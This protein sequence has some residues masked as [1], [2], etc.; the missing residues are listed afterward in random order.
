MTRRAAALLAALI[1]LTG[2]ALG[3]LASATS[4]ADSTSVATSPILDSQRFQ[5]G[6]FRTYVVVQGQDRLRVDVS[7]VVQ[8]TQAGE[9][10]LVVEACTLEPYQPC[11]DVTR[12]QAFSYVAGANRVRWRFTLVTASPTYTLSSSVFDDASEG[13]ASSFTSNQ[14][15]G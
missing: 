11:G 5:S 10:W 6:S 1:S 8:A 9:G 13:S 2:L 3:L 15:L 14:L 7:M 4:A 12:S